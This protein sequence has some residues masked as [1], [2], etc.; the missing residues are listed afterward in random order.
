MVV[1]RFCCFTFLIHRLNTTHF[2]ERNSLA[3]LELHST[4]GSIHAQS[5]IV[6]FEG[7]NNTAHTVFHNAMHTRLLQTEIVSY[8]HMVIFYLLSTLVLPKL[9]FVV[10]AH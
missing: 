7:K 1:L 4:P 10:S 2:H 8:H 5:E 6:P 3:I 9:F